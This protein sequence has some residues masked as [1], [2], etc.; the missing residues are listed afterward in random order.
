MKKLEKEINMTLGKK[1]AHLRS[2]IGISQEELAE[3]AGV[4]RQSVSK[5]EID[6]T[7]PQIDKIL[8]LCDLFDVSAD[9]LLKDT[10][11]LPQKEKSAY[12][13]DTDPGADGRASASY[14]RPGDQPGLGRSLPIR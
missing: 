7:L 5:W 2:L 13:H 3:K 4:S 14:V 6:A 10:Y 9:A 11:Q 8:I 1:I 12:A